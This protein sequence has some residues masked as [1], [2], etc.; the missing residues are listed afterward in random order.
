MTIGDGEVCVPFFKAVGAPESKGC[1]TFS[2]WAG[3]QI[4]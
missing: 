3:K 4:K 2:W 1:Q